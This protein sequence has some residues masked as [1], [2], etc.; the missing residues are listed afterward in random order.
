MDWYA[1]FV[2]FVNVFID[3]K[4]HLCP[5]ECL[6]QHSLLQNQSVIGDLIIHKL[7]ILS[8]KIFYQS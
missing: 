7:V 6:T 3:E 1:N 5:N 2:H 8:S 4:R